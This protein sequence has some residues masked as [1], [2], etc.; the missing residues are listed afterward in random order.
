MVRIE[1]LICLAVLLAPLSRAQEADALRVVSY[2]IHHAEG[3]DGLLDLER[4]AAVIQETK[5]SVVCLQEVDRGLPRTGLADMPARLG[6]LL[7]MTPVFEANYRFDGGEYGN[8]T[9]TALPIVDHENYALPGT[10]GNEPRGAL[11]VTV[12]VY[13]MEIDVF[14]THWALTREERAL[15]GAALSGHVREGMPTVITGD[16]NE[17]EKGEGVRALLSRLENTL[18]REDRPEGACAESM[19][20]DHIFVS[21]DIA[22]LASGQHRSP[23]SAVASD[24]L[25]YV[26]ELRPAPTRSSCSTRQGDDCFAH[27]LSARLAVPRPSH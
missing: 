9:L 2:N 21:P 1:V 11:R 15:Q 17:R 8:C 10:A 24:H 23:R 20:I 16:F 18:A 3:T 13:G 4:I 14:N 25:P 7:G 19:G 26:A 22:V 5:P 6:E 12:V 27:T